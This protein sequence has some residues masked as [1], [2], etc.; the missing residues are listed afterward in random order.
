MHYYS[1]FQKHVTDLTLDFTQLAINHG[2]EKTGKKKS[3]PQDKKRKKTSGRQ[4]KVR[5]K[6]AMGYEE[7]KVVHGCSSYVAIKRHNSFSVSTNGCLA[8]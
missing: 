2:H 1:E 4:R 8:F 7:A 3:R 6:T 5:K